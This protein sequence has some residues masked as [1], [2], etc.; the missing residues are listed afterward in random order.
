MTISTPRAKSR[1]PATPAFTLLEVMIAAALSTLV[2]AGVMS[3]FLLITRTSFASNSYSQMEAEARRALEVLGQDARNARDIHW[4][5]GQSVTL[6]LSTPTGDIQTT[7]AYD[8]TPNSPTL[9]CFYRVAGDATS[10]APREVLARDVAA[11]FTFR[12]YKLEQ[13]GVPSN[14][15]TNDM[16]TKQ[17]QLAMRSVRARATTV[18]TSNAVLSASFI[19]RNK[20]VTN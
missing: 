20:R 19:L 13:P 14:A 2:L 9:G 8:A 12:R 18:A 5:S 17:L 1:L 16:E 7:Y 10:V 15:A 6:T 4:N 3:S 11:D